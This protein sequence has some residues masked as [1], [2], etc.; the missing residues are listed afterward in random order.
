[1]SLQ[2]VSVLDAACGGMVWQRQLI[3]HVQTTIPN[4]RYIGVDASSVIIQ[5]NREEL[6]H[7]NFTV[8]SLVDLQIPPSVQL[9]L[10]RDALQHNSYSNIYKILRNFASS[11]ASYI[12]ITNYPEGS[13]YCGKRSGNHNIKTGG[14]FCIDLEQRPFLLTPDKK[15]KEGTSDKKWIYLYSRRNLKAQLKKFD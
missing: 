15:I 9:I 13:G 12:L 2:I 5:K 10:N 3:P 14:W 1:M 8:A 6:P 7:L 11:N 4:F